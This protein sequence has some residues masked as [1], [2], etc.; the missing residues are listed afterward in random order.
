[1]DTNERIEVRRRVQDA[2]ALYENAGKVPLLRE[3]A[4]SKGRFVSG[5]RYIFALDVNGTMLAHPTEPALTGRNLMDLMD[6]DGNTFVRK[7]V[8]TA[9]NKGYGYGDYKWHSPG[10]NDERDK[11]VFFERIDGIILCNG[12]YRPKQSVLDLIVKYFSYY[13]PC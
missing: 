9:K 12:F 5:D 2:I 8:G 3:I 11:T 10:S 4:D 7:I 1:M 13:G 6:S